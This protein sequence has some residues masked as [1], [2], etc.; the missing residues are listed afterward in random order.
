[1]AD[2]Q[3][4]ARSH[5]SVLDSCTV[6]LLRTSCCV[7][8]ALQIVVTLFALIHSTVS[9]VM[10]LMWFVLDSEIKDAL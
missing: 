3:T 2:P 4:N 6:K 9:R 7:G 8:T 5:I 10:G 1:M